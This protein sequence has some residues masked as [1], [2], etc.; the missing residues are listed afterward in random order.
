[1]LLILCILSINI[2]KA[3]NKDLIGKIIFLDPGHGGMDPGAIYK[4]IYESKINLEITKKIERKLG[5]LG[6]IVYLTRDGDYDLSLPNSYNHKRSDL[7]KRAEMINNSNCDLYLS[8]HL[9]SESTG[10]WHGAQVFYDDINSENKNIAYFF[11][12]RLKKE[13]DTDREYKKITDRFL[14]KNINRPGVLV[15]LGFLSNSNDRYL[16]MKDDYQEKVASILADTI[17]SYFSTK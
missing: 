4:D 10:I 8:I 15:E 14:F 16:L 3:K 7:S 13:L 12:E 2:V 6:A 11:Q 1:M 5:E 17:V 9:N